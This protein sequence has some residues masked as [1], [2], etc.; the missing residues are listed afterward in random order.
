LLT[1]NPF[2]GMMLTAFEVT[3][4]GLIAIQRDGV[5][6]WFVRYTANSSEEAI[7]MGYSFFQHGAT[8]NPDMTWLSEWSF[9]FLSGEAQMFDYFVRSSFNRLM[10]EQA[11]LYKGKRGGIL[12]PARD[13][14]VGMMRNLEFVTD[15]RPRASLGHIH[16]LGSI[17]AEKP[18]SDYSVTGTFSPQLKN[19]E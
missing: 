18:D 15:L 7:S 14:A 17:S 19:Y 11:R 2:C 4:L 16:A 3:M 5:S 10:N 6:K 12:Q 8:N 1:R 9:L 13:I